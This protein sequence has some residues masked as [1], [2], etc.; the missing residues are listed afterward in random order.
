MKGIFVIMA[1]TSLLLTSCATIFTGTKQTVLIKTEPPGAD[2]EVDGIRRGVTPLPVLLKK[3]F[4]GQT[5]TLKKDGFEPNIFQPETTF[6][7][8]S[9]LN[10]FGLLGWA[11]DAA[12]GAMMKYD[13]KSY[14][15]KLENI[16]K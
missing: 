9:I 6:N 3:G 2:V 1:A 16:A 7:P 10:L 11:V 13:P 15:I 8:V 12:T 5:I 14:E 4:Q